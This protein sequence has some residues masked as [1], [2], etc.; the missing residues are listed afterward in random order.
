MK[1]VTVLENVPM[2]I[3]AGGA[4]TRSEAERLRRFDMAHASSSGAS[5]FDWTRRD[6]VA[7]RG[8]VGV[9]QVPGLAVE[10]LPKTDDSNDVQGMQQNLIYMLHRSGWLRARERSFAALGRQK[11]RLIDAFVLVFADSLLDALRE[12][13]DRAYV[14]REENLG[15][16]RGRLVMS[17][18]VRRNAFHRERLFVRY[19]DFSE[20]TKLNRLLKATCRLLLRQVRSFNVARRL[21]ETVLRFDAVSDRAPSADD[22]RSGLTRQNKRFQPHLDFCRLV[23]RGESPT[24]A[25][26]TDTSFSLLFSMPRLFEAFVGAI[27]RCHRDELGLSIHRVETQHK[28]PHLVRDEGK[29]R[30]F[31]L[32]PDVVGFRDETNAQFVLDTK[33]KRLRP[34]AP[35][36]SVSQADAYQLFAYATRYS[37]PLNVLLYPA[38]RG[39][40]TETLRFAGT[41]QLLRVGF[42]NLSRNLR[43]ER[44]QL[45]RELGELLEV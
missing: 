27:L 18:H 41:N 12:G 9:V 8:Y 43:T 23:W 30:F 7:A 22:L 6:A 37:A 20:D 39:L 2:A 33:W 1:T 36:R 35:I 17:E 21:K 29:K 38:V 16:V 24:L 31:R 4:F 28:G 14:E 42:V 45:V 19:D 44:K 11:M 13:L 26:G 25:L 5:V 3:G 40:K 34:S 15:V 10:I 32:Q